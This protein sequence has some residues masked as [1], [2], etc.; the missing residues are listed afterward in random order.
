MKDEI[1]LMEEVRYREFLLSE[2]DKVK[3][4]MDRRSAEVWEEI[5]KLKGKVD[6]M[7][8]DIKLNR[9]INKPLY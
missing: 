2:L 7:K 5:F 3:S 4:D 9:I 6:N 1:K 8:N